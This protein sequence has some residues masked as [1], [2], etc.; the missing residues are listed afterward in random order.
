M[1]EVHA[2]LHVKL[3]DRCTLEVCT[4]SFAATELMPESPLAGFSHISHVR[5]LYIGEGEKNPQ[6]F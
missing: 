2:E 4:V 5:Q 6:T 1:L 3:V